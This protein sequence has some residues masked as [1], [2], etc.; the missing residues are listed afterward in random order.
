MRRF[1][2]AVVI[3]F[4]VAGSHLAQAGGHTLFG[5]VKIDEPSTGE[6][7]PMS[8]EVL[9]Y[10]EGGTLIA[11]QTIQ[12]NGRYRFLDVRDGI[13]LV[14]IEVETVEVARVRVHVSA[15]FKTD[16]R[17]DIQLQWH[18]KSTSAR[19]GVVYAGEAY[20]RSGKN[21]ALFR[22]AVSEIAK[23]NYAAAIPL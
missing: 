15:A 14:A 23:R 6:L 21:E 12:S 5:D 18:E 4:C 13:Y 11:R 3:A 7:K 9:L 2:L 22:K 16:F 1:C 10:S 17:Q 19:P 8:L 20:K